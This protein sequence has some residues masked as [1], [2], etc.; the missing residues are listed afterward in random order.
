MNNWLHETFTLFGLNLR[1]AVSRPFLPAIVIVG[2]FAVVL[3][4]VSVLSIG[5]GL[6]R[7]FSRADATDVAMVLSNGAFSES[8]S[9]LDEASVQ[10]VASEPGVADGANGPLVSPEVLT[11]V[12]VPKRGS[13]ID[14]NVVLRGVTDA[15]FNVHDKVRIVAGRRFKTGVNE[16]IV[17]QQAVREYQNLNVGDTVHVGK[18]DWK[19]VGIFTAGGNLRESEIWTD[20]RRAQDAFHMGN[21]YS[22]AWVKLSSS[23]EFEGFQAAVKKNPRLNVQVK[24]EKEYYASLAK[25][26]TGIISV[27]GIAIGILMA[28][29]AVIGAI[30]LLYTNLAARLGEMA[31]LRAVGYRRSPVLAATL[32]E[33]LTFALAGGILGGGIAYAVFNGYQAGTLAGGLQ[34]VAF[35]FAVTPGLLIGGLIF[36][37]VMGFF[38]GLFPAIR[39]ARL[40][41]TKAL[42]EA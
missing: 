20:A 39:A 9:H 29:G 30:N 17:G 34:Q 21:A 41:I 7:V 26:A 32:L 18:G 19:V 22:D 42:R 25:G 5:Q 27:V 23:S 33:A 8:G 6:S 35:Q 31:T 15:A 3:V 24:T 16:V 4:L 11:T 36:A 12:I 10:A 37:L 38:G 14:S 1:N 40:P 13:G 2:F 28:L